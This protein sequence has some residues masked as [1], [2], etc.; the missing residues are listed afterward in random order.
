MASQV[1]PEAYAGLVDQRNLLTAM[2]NA[3]GVDSSIMKTDEQLALEQQQM[4]EQQQAEMQQQQMMMEQQQVGKV[5][6]KVAPQMVAQNN[7]QN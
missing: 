6:E 2:V 1:A 5:I 3:I 7:Q 4:L